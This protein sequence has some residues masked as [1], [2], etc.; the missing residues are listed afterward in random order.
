MAAVVHKALIICFGGVKDEDSG[1]L[2]LKSMFF[3]DMLAFDMERR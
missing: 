1:G 3:N 2:S